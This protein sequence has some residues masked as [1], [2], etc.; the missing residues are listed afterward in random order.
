MSSSAI[1]LTTIPSMVSTKEALL[2]M[3]WRNG[4]GLIEDRRFRR[5][6]I[7]YNGTP[8]Q[9]NFLTDQEIPVEL[10]DR[11]G[12][13]YT[14]QDSPTLDT[15]HPTVLALTQSS[16]A[17][18]GISFPQECFQAIELHSR[19]PGVMSINWHGPGFP[20]Y[21]ATLTR[22]A[23]F[24]LW[25]ERIVIAVGDLGTG[26]FRREF[27]KLLRGVFDAILTQSGWLKVHFGVVV[28]STG[29]LAFTGPN[30]AGKTTAI[31]RCLAGELACAYGSNDK[32][33]IRINDNRLE[34]LGTPQL[35]GIRPGTLG[36]YPDLSRFADHLAGEKAYFS[37]RALTDFFGKPLR[38][39][40]ETTTIIVPKIDQDAPELALSKMEKNQIRS[41]LENHVF[42][43]SDT[44]TP[45]WLVEELLP[46][47]SR[48]KLELRH[49]VEPLLISLPWY[50]LTGD[51]AS[52]RFETIARSLAENGKTLK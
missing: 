35:I 2:N 38:V 9:L 3:T 6:C 29:G 36:C 50:R 8:Y 1:L 47:V 18:L 32:C 30:G 17:D 28:T 16:L 10:L 21:V 26:F 31:A 12:D 46:G 24:V 48:L 42:T 15:F 22:D 49:R 23:Q 4:L 37:P 5:L 34:G 40:W 45:N 11:L 43:F 39:Q 25:S 41:A 27:I 33:Y 7:T 13:Y 14:V 44:S 19:T 51:F 52:Y 20:K